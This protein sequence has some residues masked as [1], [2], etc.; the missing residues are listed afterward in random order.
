[1]LEYFG[2]LCVSLICVGILALPAIF[3]DE[4]DEDFCG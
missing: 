4:N 1:M 3:T 2:W